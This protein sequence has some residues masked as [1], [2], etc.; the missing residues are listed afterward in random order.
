[1]KRLIKI[2]IL[3]ILALATIAT[4]FEFAS[5][6]D[7]YWR[8]HHVV[9]PWEKRVVVTGVA[10]GIVAGA[11]I[12]TRPRV[13]YRTDPVIVDEAPIY[14]NEDVYSEAPVYADPGEDYDRHAYR[15][16]APDADDYASPGYDDDQ[17]LD[18]ER[19]PNY[20]DDYFPE[21]PATRV[22]RQKENAVRKEATSKVTPKKTATTPRKQANANMPTTWSKEWR[23][24]CSSRFPS[25][26]P[27]NGTYLGY[28]KKRHFCKAT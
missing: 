7:R 25:F 26:N 22:E 5:A 27:Q 23:D 17:F 3:S 16:T 20:G 4:T 2:V 28:D 18:E 14:D 1:M 12:A 9:K 8:R 19:A 21:R 10:A 6:G 11:V 15:Y 13:I 24:W